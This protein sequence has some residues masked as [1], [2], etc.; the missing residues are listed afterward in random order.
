M[1]RAANLAGD[2]TPIKRREN[3]G[4]DSRTTFDQTAGP[5]LSSQVA[6]DPF[7]VP[8][9]INHSPNNRPVCIQSVKNPVGKNPAKTA[10]VILMDYTMNSRRDLQTVNIGTQTSGK[11]LTQ[12][13]FLRLVEKESIVEILKR[14]LR[15]LHPDHLTPI[16]PFTVSQSRS[17]A[18]P[19]RTRARRLSNKSFCS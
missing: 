5:R 13:A 7:R 11:I 12:P 19:A 17:C 14:I 9:Q 18:A 1:Q 3:G 10:V 2:P 4:D 6:A 16:V 8:S 15:N